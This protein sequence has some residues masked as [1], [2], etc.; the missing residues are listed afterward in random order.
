MVEK[1]HLKE[2]KAFDIFSRILFNPNDTLCYS[3]LLRLHQLFIDFSKCIAYNNS[4]WWT[5]NHESTHVPAPTHPQ[6]YTRINMHTSRK[7]GRKREKN[8]QTPS[9]C[10]SCWFTKIPV[11]MKTRLNWSSKTLLAQKYT[12]GSL[13]NLIGLSRVLT[14]IILQEKE[15]RQW[16]S[17]FVHFACYPELVLI[18]GIS[19]FYSETS[20]INWY[21]KWQ[22]VVKISSF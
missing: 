7:I 21:W 2:F 1:K 6:A 16:R 13:C 19:F 22:S 4:V 3:Q 20:N 12:N 10:T 15:D 9:R 17:I 11:K 5:Q 14:Q 18:L 8:R